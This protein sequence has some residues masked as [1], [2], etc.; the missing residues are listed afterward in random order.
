M[1]GR[2]RAAAHGVR[3]RA[4]PLPHCQLLRT[5]ALAYLPPVPA[6]GVG[7]VHHLVVLERRAIRRPQ[8]LPD[9]VEE[10]H[11]QL[12]VLLLLD[13]RRVAVVLMGVVIVS[14]MIMGLMIGV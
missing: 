13:W 9:L 7:G 11:C 10:A 8:H 4:W 3:P 5:R 6:R 2:P 14:L 1:H 12:P